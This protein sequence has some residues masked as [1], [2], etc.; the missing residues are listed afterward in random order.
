MKKLLLSLLFLAFLAM[1]ALAVDAGSD[2]DNKLD[3]SI[4]RISTTFQTPSFYY[5][6]RWNAAKTKSGQGIVVGKNLVLTLASNVNNATSI[7]MLLGSEPVPAQLKVKVMNIESNLALLEGEIPVECVPM[8]IPGTSVYKRNSPLKLFW[9]TATGQLIEGSAVLDRADTRTLSHTWQSHIVLQAIRSSHPNTGFGVPVFDAEGVFFGLSLGGGNEYEFSIITCDTI[10]KAFDFNSGTAKG[11]TA[12]P[13]FATEPL[14][15][16][17]YRDKLGLSQD[18]GGCLVSRVFGQGSGAS[19]LAQ[20]DVILEIS[21]HSID[22]RGRYA[23]PAYGLLFFHHLFSGHFVDDKM[24]AVIVRDGHR[25]Q[26]DLDLSSYDDSRWLIPKNPGFDESEYFIRGGFVFIPLTLTYLLEWGADFY[27]K[28]PL[29]LVSVEK[30]H[31]TDT[32]DSQIE[33]FV[34]LSGVMPH[35]SNIA[36]QQMGGRVIQR[37]NGEPLRG[38]RHLKEVF[39]TPGA[40]VVKLDLSPGRT[41]LWL[42]PET[43]RAVD[44][45]IQRIYGISKLE[46]FLR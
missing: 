24:S 30:K 5:P 29:P 16:V 37:I 34:V 41:P 32:I 46:R 11:D 6:W 43:L 42:C 39:D 9:K 17:F 21:G 35:P 14:L 44:G 15:Q 25:M 8:E 20:G 12:L 40:D 36:L 23:H 26:L 10:G 31:S 27:N 13:G 2:D 28:A 38:L 33:G 18:D 1:P 22:A 4:V 3:L 45:D 19:Q 7:E